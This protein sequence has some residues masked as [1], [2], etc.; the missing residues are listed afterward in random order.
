[1]KKTFLN[2]SMPQSCFIALPFHS[3]PV[4]LKDTSIYLN[5]TQGAAHA[6]HVSQ[7]QKKCLPPEDKFRSGGLNA[8]L[9]KSRRQLLVCLRGFTDFKT[10]IPVLDENVNILFRP[11]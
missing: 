1:V 4:N 8:F 6:H 5:R 7:A 2:A 10:S 11:Y 3:L 9:Q